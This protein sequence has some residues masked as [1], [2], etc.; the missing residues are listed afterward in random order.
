MEECRIGRLASHLH[1]VAILLAERTKGFSL[2]DWFVFKVS[3]AS[4]GVLLGTSFS[5]CLKRIFP[6]IFLTSFISCGYIIWKLL[7]SYDE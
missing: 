6:V 3:V 5:K 7:L 4:F 2:L 1:S